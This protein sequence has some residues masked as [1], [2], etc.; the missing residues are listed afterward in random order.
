MSTFI[1]ILAIYFAIGIALAVPVLM[2]E[3]KKEKK[4]FKIIV[5]FIFAMSLYG[6]FFCNL[7]YKKIK[8]GNNTKRKSRNFPIFRR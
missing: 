6:W 4:L 7:I 1:I 8:S 5:I 3:V 2:I